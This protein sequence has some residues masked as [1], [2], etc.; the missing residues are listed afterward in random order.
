MNHPFGFLNRFLYGFKIA[1]VTKDY[2]DYLLIFSGN[3]AGFFVVYFE[4]CDFMMP[5]MRFANYRFSDVSE[6]SCN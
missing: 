1:D 3:F 5:S 2:S 6:S 4:N